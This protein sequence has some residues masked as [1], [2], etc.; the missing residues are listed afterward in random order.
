MYMEKTND[1]MFAATLVRPTMPQF[2]SGIIC[3]SHPDGE[4]SAPYESTLIPALSAVS[5]AMKSMMTRAQFFIWDNWRTSTSATQNTIPPTRSD[6][7]T[8]TL[9]ETCSRP[10]TWGNDDRRSAWT[11][12][13][14]AH[15]PTIRLNT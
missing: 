9:P 6:K 13:T 15:V 5:H 11:T 1:A 14:D 2:A 8:T 7:A 10:R 3:T 12:T 4:K